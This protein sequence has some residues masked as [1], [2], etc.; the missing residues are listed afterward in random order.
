MKKGEMNTNQIYELAKKELDIKSKG[1]VLKLLKKR[2][3]VLLDDLICY[4]PV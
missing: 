2:K 1:Q 3:P 4:Q